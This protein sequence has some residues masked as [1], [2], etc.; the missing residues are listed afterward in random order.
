MEFDAETIEIKD[1][2]D[3][4]K[5]QMRIVKLRLPP[6]QNFEYKAG[7]FVMLAMEGFVLHSNSN[8]LKWTSYSIASS[9]QQQGML[10]FCIKIRETGGFTQFLRDNLQLGKKIK[11]KGPYGNFCCEQPKKH[12]LL[13]GAGSGIAPMLSLARNLLGNGAETEITC[14]YGFRNTNHW[15]YKDEMEQHQKN[16]KNFTYIPTQSRPDGKW[17]GKKGY[18]QDVLKLIKVEEPVET[19]AFVCGNPLMVAENKKLL[20]ERGVP[21]ANIHTEQWEGA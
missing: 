19:Q 9:Q 18:V 11:V 7:Q 1:Y 15:V 13:L 12:V 10:E 2:R 5:V 20:L 6:D 4:D 14:I 16:H 21:A 8:A 3:E 17:I